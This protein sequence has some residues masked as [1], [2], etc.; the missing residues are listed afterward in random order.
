MTPQTRFALYIIRQ[1]FNSAPM[2][3]KRAVER[4][5][6]VLCFTS[7]E[8]ESD[9]EVTGPLKAKLYISSDVSDTDF[10]V[11]LVDVLPSGYAMRVN[12]NICKTRFRNSLKKAEAMEPGKVY[13][14]DVDLWATSQVFKKGHRIRVEICSSAFP[15]FAR[16]LNTGEKTWIWDGYKNCESGDLSQLNVSFIYPTAG[17]PEIKG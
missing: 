14:L 16:N 1:V 13:E 12:D 9:L 10:V 6:D 11:R 5:D 17:Y 4:R 3:T 7:D 8:L 15:K 2:K